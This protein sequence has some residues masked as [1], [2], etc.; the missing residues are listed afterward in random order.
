MLIGRPP[1]RDER[2]YLR[3]GVNPQGEFGVSSGKIAVFRKCR[4]LE[5]DTQIAQLL[6]V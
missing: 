5:L 6:V 3:G 2:R 4:P 1:L